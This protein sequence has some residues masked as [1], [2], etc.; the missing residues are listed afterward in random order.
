MRIRMMAERDSRMMAYFGERVPEDTTA[1]SSSGTDV[2]R[3]RG[4][5]KEEGG[6]ERGERGERE[7]VKE[8]EKERGEERRVGDR[9]VAV[10]GEIVGV[11]AASV[12][13]EAAS[14]LT[15]WQTG[16]TGAEFTLP[17]SPTQVVP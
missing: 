13:S 2:V 7:E 5:V 4:S 1:R 16:S 14:S 15:E 8:E 9:G 12:Q 11:K 17:S 10:K 6:R 3:W